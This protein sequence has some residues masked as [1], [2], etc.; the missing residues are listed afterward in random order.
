MEPAAD[1][2]LA[3]AAVLHLGFQATVTA[4]VYPA[5]A[6][7]G[8]KHPDDWQSAHERH[9]RSIV[10]LVAIVYAALLASGVWSLASTPGPLALLAVA[11]SWAA[12]LVT[13]TVAAPTHGR[14]TSPDPT[15]LQRLLVA[16]RWRCAAASLGAVAALAALIR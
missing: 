9:S 7:V 8:L 10:P 1:I 13:G 4:L 3:L 2:A 14:L 5:L 6:R 15:L 12:V 11:G 16:D